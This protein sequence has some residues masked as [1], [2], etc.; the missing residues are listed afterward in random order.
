M[1]HPQTDVVIPVH[2]ALDYTE[3]C[4]NSVFAHTPQINRLILV[5]DFSQPEVTAYLLSVLVNHSSALYIRTGTQRW[6]T[7]ASNLGL[8]L[9]RTSRCVLLNS[10]CVVDKDWLEELYA[11]WTDVEETLPGK[12]IGLVGSTLSGEEPRRWAEY[13]EPGYVTGHCL[14]LSVAVLSEISARRGMPGIYLDEVHQ[15][16]IHINSDRFLSYELNQAGYV[17][18]ASFKSAVGHHGGKSW[19]HNLAKISGLT[20]T[21]PELGEIRG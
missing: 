6:F 11:V 14:L 8:R 2:N 3:A 10:D 4:I 1:S 15:N 9:V 19:G 7:R 17:T 12:R 5:D 16:A 20:M 18:V 21:S 13:R